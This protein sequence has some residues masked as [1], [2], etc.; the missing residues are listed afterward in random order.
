MKRSVPVLLALIL[1]VS[2]GSL[3]AQRG[4]GGGRGP[5]VPDAPPEML[6]VANRIVEAINTQDSDALQAM[7]A[8]DAVYLDEDGHALPPAIWAMRLTGGETANQMTISATHGQVFGDTGWVSFNY[9][10]QTPDPQP[11]TL[12]GTASLVLRMTGGNWR[13]QLV[14]GALEQ[15]VAGLTN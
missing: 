5:A 13:I 4:R 15:H 2:S 10:L 8:A 3:L 6:N 12:R 14:H 1:A 9:T 11:V 7:L